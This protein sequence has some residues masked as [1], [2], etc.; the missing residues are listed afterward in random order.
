[1]SEGD[2]FCFL[3]RCFSFEINCQMWTILEMAL[4]H[5]FHM[6]ICLLKGNNSH[7]KGKIVFA[8]KM[9]TLESTLF[10]WNSIC[11]FNM[12][13]NVLFDLENLTISECFNRFKIV[14]WILNN[15]SITFFLKRLLSPINWPLRENAHTG[16]KKM[17]IL[18]D[19]QWW[20]IIINVF[21]KFYN[22]QIYFVR[23]RFCH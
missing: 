17:T 7:S 13:L 12:F 8:I 11:N 1:M 6:N 21:R 15:H 20:Q 10:I 4:D 16:E 18:N 19:F 2:V 22:H 5:I 9:W 14:F 3:N 23:K